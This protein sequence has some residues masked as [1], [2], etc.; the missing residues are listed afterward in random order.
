MRCGNGTVIEPGDAGD[1]LGQRLWNAD[2]ADASA[3]SFFGRLKMGQV[4]VES[5]PHLRCRTAEL[6]RSLGDAHAVHVQPVLLRERADAGDVGR[7][8]AVKALEFFGWL[9]GVAVG[10]RLIG[11]QPNGDRDAFVRIDAGDDRR[12]RIGRLLAPGD[13]GP[14]R[15][16]RIDVHETSNGGRFEKRCAIVHAGGRR[17]KVRRSAGARSCGS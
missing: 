9:P 1:R 15:A 5:L 6:D 8:R 12:A 11:A 13:D 17:S 4:D 3:V 7:T 14:I 10:D 2:R 16:R